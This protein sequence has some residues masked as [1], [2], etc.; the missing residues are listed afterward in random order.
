MIWGAADGIII[1]IKCTVN[2]LCLNHI[3]I[4]PA[5][6]TPPLP[7]SVGK[8]SSMKA[9][10]GAK[11]FGDHCS[12]WSGNIRFI[13]MISFWLSLEGQKQ[14]SLGFP[15]GSHGKE[16]ACNAG[17]SGSIPRLA[18]ISWRREWPLTPVF[19]PGE[20]HGQRS[21]V[22]YTPWGCKELVMTE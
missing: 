9:V 8:L 4:T 13:A 20:F 10:P 11:N 12:K 14:N 5:P 2:V 17:D 18:K 16:F 15:G 21:L 1:K 22:G 6:S 19:L 7:Q 3:N